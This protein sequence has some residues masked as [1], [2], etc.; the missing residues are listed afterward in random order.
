MVKIAA[1]LAGGLGTRLRQVLLQRPKALA[2]VCGRPFLSYLLDYIADCGIEGA[3][4]CTGYL[5]DQI[6]MRFGDVYKTVQ[7]HYSQ[8]SSPLGTAGA[9]RLAMPFFKSDVILVM[10]GDS[11][12][13]VAMKDFWRW[14]CSH[15]SEA[16]LLLVK[17]S[18]T[19]RFG[20]VETDV[21]GRIVRFMEKG[22]NGPGLINAGIYLLKRTFLETIPNRAPLSL[23]RD[24]FP[25][26]IGR[27]FFG[28]QA[29][30][31]LIDIGTPESLAD[32]EIFCAGRRWL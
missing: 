2:E 3:I 27:Q 19:G 18:D 6:Q 22:G 23:E 20:S 24:V 17:S 32:A 7:L 1:V 30:D 11:L 5:G 25:S 10:N 8:E 9:L 29:P 28:Y 31:Q 21:N 13:R 26:W 15:R 16:S 12:C 14:H 4:I